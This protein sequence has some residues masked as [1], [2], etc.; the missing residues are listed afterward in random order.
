MKEEE[1][2][3]FFFNIHV[4]IILESTVFRN[5]RDQRYA[6]DCMYSVMLHCPESGRVGDGWSLAVAGRA[7]G[8]LA[9]NADL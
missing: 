6:S 1:K 9:F 7:L 2:R 3:G 8:V 4:F 5:D